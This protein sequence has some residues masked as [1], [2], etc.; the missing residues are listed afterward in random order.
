LRGDDVVLIHGRTIAGPAVFDLRTA[1]GGA[2]LSVQEAL[3]R[4]GIDTFAPSLLASAAR[5]GSTRA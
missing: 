4:A 2:E 5:P 1:T 3:A